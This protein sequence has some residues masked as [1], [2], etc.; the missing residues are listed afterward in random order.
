LLFVFEEKEQKQKKQ[1]SKK[2]IYIGE[3]RKD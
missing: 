2:K 3:R 1:K